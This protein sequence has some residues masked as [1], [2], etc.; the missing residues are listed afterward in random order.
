[1]ALGASPTKLIGQLLTESV[2]LAVIGGGL[3]LLLA[4]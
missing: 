3:G 4:V 2:L 1:V